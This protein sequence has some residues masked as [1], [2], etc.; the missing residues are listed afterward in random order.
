MSARTVTVCLFALSLVMSAGCKKA[1]QVP[2]PDVQIA[3]AADDG[4]FCIY[5]DSMP[6]IVG[7]SYGT[8]STGQAGLTEDTGPVLIWRTLYRFDL[9]GWSSGDA[10]FWVYVMARY[11]TAPGL[12]FV[13]VD[14]FG[15]VPTQMLACGDMSRLWNLV[16]SGQSL[17]SF[18]TEDTGW[19][20]VT[21][22]AARMAAAKSATGWLGLVVKAGSEQIVPGNVQHLATFEAQPDVAPQPFLAW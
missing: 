4:P 2:T 5:R 16:D 19:V 17:A 7:F 13:A 21:I 6:A 18:F 22:P 9:S 12:E 14:D 15:S 1:D 3:V 20:H 10:D 11:G 8:G